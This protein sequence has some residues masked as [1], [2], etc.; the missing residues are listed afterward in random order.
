M[1]HAETTRPRSGPPHPPRRVRPLLALVVLVACG[2][3]TG[4]RTA[5]DWPQDRYPEVGD[6]VVPIRLHA[7]GPTRPLREGSATRLAFLL[8][9][10]GLGDDAWEPVDDQL[11]FGIDFGYEPPDSLLGVEIGGSVSYDEERRTGEDV[12][13]GVADGYVG[14]RRTF[15]RGARVQP[16]VGAGVAVLDA[17]VR[18]PAVEDDDQQSFAGSARAGIAWFAGESWFVGLDARQVLGTDLDLA[19][20]PDDFDLLALSFT[21]GVGY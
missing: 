9:W 6:T 1:S 18:G 10:R 20:A 3:A 4:R 13:L 7:D 11:L 17:R 12:E 15:A 14:L 16:Y 21:I 19:G 5:Q 8:G 2:C